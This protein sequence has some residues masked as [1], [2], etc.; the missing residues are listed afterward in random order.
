MLIKLPR[1]WAL[2]LGLWLVV[3]ALLFGVWASKPVLAVGHVQTGDN[4]GRIA[5]FVTNTD[6]V[7]LAGI[8]VIAFQFDSAILNEPPALNSPTPWGASP[9]QG[10]TDGTGSYQINLLPPGSYHLIFIDDTY[11]AEFYRNATTISDATAIVVDAKQTMKGIDASLERGASISAYVGF[12]DGRPIYHPR[13]LNDCERSGGGVTIYQQAG[14]GWIPY[15][16]GYF[17]PSD[18]HFNLEAS[19]FTVGG[20]APGVYRV[21]YDVFKNRN[22][23]NFWFSNPDFEGFYAQTDELSQATNITMIAGST[24]ENLNIYVDDSPRYGRIQG[25]VQSVTGEPLPCIEVY[26]YTKITGSNIP[27][28]T[29]GEHD[30]TDGNGNYDLTVTETGEYTLRF[31]D[32]NGNYRFEY[33]HDQPTLINTNIITAST[34]LTVSGVDSVLDN[35]IQV[36]GQ[37]RLPDGALWSQVITNSGSIHLAHYNGFDWELFQLVSLYDPSRHFDP[38]TS[39]YNF[40]GL[41]PGL[42]RLDFS[43]SD[44]E[45]YYESSITTTINTTQTLDIVPQA[46]IEPPPPPPTDPTHGQVY[47]R[48]TDET[49]KPLSNIAVVAYWYNPQ[50]LTIPGA[51]PWMNTIEMDTWFPTFA[52]TDRD[53]YYHIPSLW[54]GQFTLR[55]GDPS[56]QHA[57]E[58]YGN[59][60][61]LS[62]AMTITIIAG[63]VLQNLDAQLSTGGQ[64]TG[65]VKFFASAQPFG[66]P[67]HD[68]ITLSYDL[69]YGFMPMRTQKDFFP[70]AYNDSGIN[71]D[72][73]TGVYTITGLVHGLNAVTFSARRYLNGAEIQYTETYT[74]S[75]TDNEIIYHAVLVHNDN[76][77]VLALYALALDHDPDRIDNL[78]PQLAPAMQS[79]IAATRDQPNKTAVVLADAAGVGDTRIYV[80]RNG[81]ATPVQG[82]PTAAFQLD[83]TATEANMADGVT[84]GNFIRWARNTYPAEVTLFG[85][86][87]HGAPLVPATGFDTIVAASGGIRPRTLDSLFP[88]PTRVGAYPSLT[89]NHPQALITPYDL[90][91]A[92]RIGSNN[93]ADPLQIADVAHCFAASIEELYELSPDGDQPYA[94]IILASPTYTYLDPPALGEAL[95]AINTLMT[96]A[97][98]AD[99]ILQ[100]Y[101]ALI[102]Q[103][104]QSDGDAEVE[105]PRLL[106]AVNSRQ[107][108]RVKQDWDKV[109]YHLLQNFDSAK[110]QQAYQASPH[111]DTTVCHPQDWSLSP[112]DAL[113]DLYGF[114]AA[115]VTVY[116][117]D[118][119]VGKAATVVLRD[120]ED[121]TILSRYQGNGIPWYAPNGAPL[122]NFD[123]HQGIA[124]FADLQGQPTTQAGTVELSWQSRWYTADSLAGENPHPYAFVQNGF[125]GVTWATVF[126]EFWRRQPGVT[127]QTALCFPE[128]ASEP[129]TGELEIIAL[130][131]PLTGTVRVGLPFTPTA[132]VQTDRPTLKPVI[133]FNLYNTNHTL[134]LSDTVQGGYW[135]TGTHQLAAARPY[136]PT[137]P[138][139]LTLEVIVDPANNVSEA[140]EADNRLSQR[141]SVAPPERFPLVISARLAEPTF[142]VNQG[143]VELQALVS[144]AESATTLVAQL[145]QFTNSTPSAPWQPTLSTRQSLDLAKPTL[146]LHGLAPGMVVAHIW[147]RTAQG[148]YSAQPA[149]VIFNY[150]PTNQPLAAGQTHYY[151]LTTPLTTPVQLDLAVSGDVDL[152]AWSPFNGW[153]P[154]WR[155]AGSPLILPASVL[156]DGYLLAVTAFADSHYTLTAQPTA[157][158]PTTANATPELSQSWPAARPHLIQPVID[159]PGIGALAAGRQFFLPLAAR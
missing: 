150:A 67:G 18:L 91:A 12:L 7:P 130:S 84:L 86:V 115:L 157:A 159:P 53:G 64:L 70:G 82:L 127:I 36:S 37:V 19:T 73:P 75:V 28:Q 44:G 51:I 81:R 55:F 16:G 2:R 80:V 149:V 35:G 105:H 98:M 140:N 113:T 125:N 93:G 116:G 40:A 66:E 38:A 24:I 139:D 90:A 8:Q 76:Q 56:W 154:E 65:R 122:W 22:Y 112:P 32:P 5:G 124:L 21:S 148:R 135:L 14:P 50:L 85:F 49:G 110:L 147:A 158:T 61:D 29:R 102:D 62:S 92:L 97:T 6:G 156:T 41:A 42:Y 88:L 79:I 74:F 33:Y 118:S 60:I 48:V 25:H 11:A 138:G 45:L 58:F 108:A 83:P 129:R 142:F 107:V 120:L 34:G 20:L 106:V 151:W 123:N 57:P 126:A 111:Y 46:I 133:R 30:L 119:A 1:R 117:A 13:E 100:R 59:S 137:A 155:M 103:A 104:D 9:F 114:A 136:T 78:A 52:V 146:P 47:G 10:L 23:N 31:Y 132:V 87:G 15:W 141:Y 95:G 43:G 145:Y 143:Q 69:G 152:F 96:P 101:D 72:P 27:W 99:Q 4:T 77:R 153:G 131:A 3:G 109:A 121:T 63:S 94:E 144:P 128:L 71:L 26:A 134:L 68:Q 39:T 54:P 89:D 17:E